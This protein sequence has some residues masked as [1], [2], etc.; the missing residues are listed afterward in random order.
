MKFFEKSY[1][2]LRAA[3]DGLR[4]FVL[5]NR[6]D[7]PVELS[8]I[9][10]S[11]PNKSKPATSIDVKT[12]E[13]RCAQI[14]NLFEYLETSDMK[15]HLNDKKS[16]LMLKVRISE[17][18]SEISSDDLNEL[19]NLCKEKSIII[20]LTAIKDFKCFIYWKLFNIPN[21]MT[22]SHYN[23]SFVHE[24]REVYNFIADFLLDCLRH[25]GMG[26]CKQFTLNQNSTKIEISILA[27]YRNYNLLLLAAE[28]GNDSVVESLLRNGINEESPDKSVDAQSLAWKGRHSEV[29]ITL[30][31]HDLK[32]P[33]G[34]D[35]SQLSNKFKAFYKRI[36]DFHDAIRVKDVDKVKK[37]INN[38]NNNN[39]KY[40][41]NIDN[42]SAASTAIQA[43]SF[44][45]YEI[46]LAN[47][48]RFQQDE[49]VVFKKLRKTEQR[50]LREIHLKYSNDLKNK[51]ISILLAHSYVGHNASESQEKLEYVKRAYETLSQDP[52]LNVILLV[53][54]A[55]RKLKIVYDFL[56]ESVDI[57][58]PTASAYTEGNFYPTGR[59]YIGAK[60]LL[61]E[62]TKYKTLSTMAHEFAHYAIN[63]TYENDAKPYKAKNNKSQGEF[64]KIFKNCKVNAS[65][66]QVINI[67]YEL[68]PRG[69]Q[70]A[71]LIV[72]A[73][74]LIAL[75]FVQQEKLKETVAL[76]PKLFE[77]YEKKVILDMMRMLPEIENRA[78]KN[79]Q[80]LFKKNKS[81]KT[82]LIIVI[83]LV[84]LGGLFTG[85]FVFQKLT[86]F[87][88][89]RIPPSIHYWNAD[90]NNNNEKLGSNNNGGSTSTYDVQQYPR[91]SNNFNNLG[92]VRNA[93]SN[94][95]N[96]KL[97]S[98][99]NGGS[100]STDNVQQF[101]RQSNEFNNL[102][103]V[104]PKPTSFNHPNPEQT[105]INNNFG[106]ASEFP[107]PT[108]PNPEQT[109]INNNFGL[110][111]EFPQPTYPNPEQTFINNNYGLV[112]GVRRPTYPNP[113][114]PYFGVAQPTF[115][116]QTYPQQNLIN[117]NIG[118]NYHTYG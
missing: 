25:G 63:L 44:E 98:K 78:E 102:G 68:Y 86:N 49:K 81:L 87:K 33:I 21:F 90:S 79:I 55:S 6:E 106:L 23:E 26:F 45:I 96:E 17:N 37:V 24:D 5:K 1:R 29:L 72:R 46:L 84:S 100:Q 97:G 14:Q 62:D 71:E 61:N 11:N 38:N 15:A 35:I 20:L 16:I 66:E 64:R 12:T 101:P 8:S 31:N 27:D 104:R 34:I 95:N 108:Y 13:C 80:T 111:S 105:F 107:Q 40:F 47:G 51:H 9:A 65:K 110:A 114:H 113:Q 58:D 82:Y 22:I 74:H 92:S 93:D 32:Y 77:F 19:N 99:S 39:L 69:M 67:V 88:M 42:V 28:I 103:R 2:N 112:S 4:N 118:N 48:F 76:F 75:Y 116:V 89:E 41:Y 50:Q 70:H 53:I 3:S 36:E 60:Q 117:R 59:I 54:A 73:P 85:F 7:E 30:A 83:L 109:F 57:V 94:N 10:V 18:L 52:R 56:S 91:Q 115:N 43:K